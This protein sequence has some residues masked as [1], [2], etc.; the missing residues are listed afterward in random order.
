[1]TAE[2]IVEDVHPTL[3]HEER[4]ALGTDLEGVLIDL[5]DLSL[6]GKQLHWNVQ[7]ANFRSLHLQLDEL[8]DVWRELSDQVAERAVALGVAPDGRAAT[9]AGA[10]ELQAPAAG[11]L[12]THEVI[13]YLT[14][15]L[16]EVI[17]RARKRMEQT[18]EYDDV[19]NDLLIAVVAKL[20]EQH[21]MVR[22]QRTA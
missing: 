13:D 20:E 4:Q 9:V 14:H 18:A 10:T 6:I 1:V 8:I 3:R 15:R 5:I 21:W 11:P 7:G 16:A 17:T 2:L 22:V 19:T 12:A